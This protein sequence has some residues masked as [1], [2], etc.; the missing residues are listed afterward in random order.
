MKILLKLLPA[1]VFTQQRQAKPYESLHTK[2]QIE[3]EPVFK[4]KKS[5]L[6]LDLQIRAW[7]PSV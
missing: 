6:V 2:G 1:P 5:A 7:I 3:N 4:K